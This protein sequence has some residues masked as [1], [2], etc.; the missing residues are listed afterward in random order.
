[1]WRVGP[2]SA[3]QRS[4]FKRTFVLRAETWRS[5]ELHRAWKRQ[6]SLPFPSIHTRGIPVRDHLYRSA[7]EV[8]A[9]PAELYEPAY[10]MA[11]SARTIRGGR[12][13]NQRDIGGGVSC[14]CGTPLAVVGSPGVCTM[15]CAEPL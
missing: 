3:S 1:V 10:I 4:N 12:E 2:E 11:I 5:L 7:P 8:V 15:S 14:L 13:G 9:N 6:K